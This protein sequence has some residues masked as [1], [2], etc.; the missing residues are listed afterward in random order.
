MFESAKTGSGYQIRA[1]NNP[2]GA[3]VEA[4][5]VFRHTTAN[6]A[7]FTI[8]T[9]VPFSNLGTVATTDGQ[10]YLTGRSCNAER[11]DSRRERGKWEAAAR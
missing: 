10:L 5:G 2:L 8:R 7:D 6:G 9:T 1:L 4:G 11:A 3:F